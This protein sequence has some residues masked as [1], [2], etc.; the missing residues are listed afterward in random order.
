MWQALKAF[1]DS[2]KQTKFFI[3]MFVIYMAAIIWTTLQAYVRLEYS[4][5]DKETPI[6]IQ[7]EE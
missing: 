5:S 1:K 2:N 6:I 3:L 7:S 4:R